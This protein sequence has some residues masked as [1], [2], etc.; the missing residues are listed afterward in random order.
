M[1]LCIFVCVFAMYISSSGS[2]NSGSNQVL[3]VIMCIRSLF[4]ISVNLALAGV[5]GQMQWSVYGTAAYMS[6]PAFVF[7]SPFCLISKLSL[8]HGQMFL[9]SA[10]HQTLLSCGEWR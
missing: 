4:G 6:L 3:R 10:V 8:V 5:L 1:S 2:H 9:A 7:P